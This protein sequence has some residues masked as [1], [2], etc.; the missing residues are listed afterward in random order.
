MSDG[1]TQQRATPTAAAHTTRQRQTFADILAFVA[2]VDAYRRQLPL[3]QP[4]EREAE[5]AAERVVSAEEEEAMNAIH[6]PMT[7]SDR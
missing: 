5:P 1:N 3:T 4:R 6:G 2:R 7:E